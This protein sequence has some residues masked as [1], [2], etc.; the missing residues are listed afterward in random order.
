M[1]FS[2]LEKA[3]ISASSRTQPA[4]HRRRIS[5]KLSSEGH[6]LADVWI[7]SWFCRALAAQR[8]KSKGEKSWPGSKPRPT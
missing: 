3:S 4:F 6:P 8:G 5:V 1:V 2:I 7:V